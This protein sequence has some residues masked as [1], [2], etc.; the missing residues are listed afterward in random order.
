MKQQT[1]ARWRQLDRRPVGHQCPGEAASLLGCR[2]RGVRS[3]PWRT[4]RECVG[5]VIDR[6]MAQGTAGRDSMVLAVESETAPSVS[7]PT[8]GPDT[9]VAVE[10]V[11]AATAPTL[12]DETYV[13]VREVVWAGIETSGERRARWRRRAAGLEHEAESDVVPDG[14]Q[15]A[16]TTMLKHVVGEAPRPRETA[17]IVEV[18]QSRTDQEQALDRQGRQRA[19]HGGDGSPRSGLDEDRERWPLHRQ[20]EKGDR[21]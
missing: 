15:D 5:T 1:E 14:S 11:G 18:G 8:G 17:G 10:V 21:S 7:A 6:R 3:G 13:L 4:V 16:P 19:C 2:R 9:G 12:G 20:K